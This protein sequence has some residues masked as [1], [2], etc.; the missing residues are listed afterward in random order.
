M[1]DNQADYY[2]DIKSTKAYTLPS[3]FSKRIN[4]FISPSPF[5]KRSL[6]PI[7]PLNGKFNESNEKAYSY[8][9]PI[10]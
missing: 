1:E 10:S 6:L 9:K 3:V 5:I 4:R 8:T 2:T 7:K